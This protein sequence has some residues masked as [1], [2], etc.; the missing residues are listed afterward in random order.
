MAFVSEATNLGKDRDVTK[1]V[2][3]RDLRTDV[4]VRRVFGP[5]DG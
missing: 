2:F 1:D 4:F 3:V 5:L